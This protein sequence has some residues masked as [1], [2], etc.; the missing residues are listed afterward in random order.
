MKTLRIGICILAAFSVLAFGTV[1]IWSQTILE[2]GAAL[3]LLWWAVVIFRK[4][5][6]QIRWSPC[7]WPLL[8]F[9]VLVWAQL[10]FRVTAYAF[11]TRVAVIELLGCVILFF[12]CGQA[13]RERRELRYFAWFLMCFAFAIAI[14]AIAQSFTSNGKLYWVRPLTAGGNPFGPYVNRNHFAGLMEMLSPVG[15]SLLLFRGVRRE[16]MAL[17]G[18]LTIVPIAAL[19]LSGSRGGIVSFLFE[20][21]LLAVLVAYQKKEK[22]HRAAV[23]A[24]LLAVLAAVG[25]L[26]TSRLFERFTHVHEGEVSLERR[27]TMF[28]GT[29]R[30]FVDHP[31]TGTGLGTLVDVYP[32][33]ETYYDGK[34]VDH[35]HNDYVELLAETGITGGLCGLVFFWLFFRDAWSRLRAEQ[36]SL[37]VGLHAGAVVA[38]A[39]M[40]VH[41]LVDFNF[42]TPSNGLF[43][44]LMVS[45]AITPVLPPRT[46]SHPT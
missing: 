9:V 20:L 39:G 24:V 10:L 44:L 1:E 11:Y 32:R 18:L 43:F 29:W 21:G 35:A 17:A 2:V 37:S 27:W 40:L 28:V 15:L 30:I 26:G 7:Y 33:Y 42:H 5:E 6:T 25:W 13:F 45:L 12:L 23:A 34:I 4:T 16:Q 36:S 41:S 3:L 31:V 38:C 22:L 46:R 14:F 19:I 8:A